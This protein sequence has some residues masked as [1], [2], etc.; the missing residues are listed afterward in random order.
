LLLCRSVEVEDIVV[1]G[2][3]VRKLKALPAGRMGN[4]ANAFVGGFRPGKVEASSRSAQ[5]RKAAGS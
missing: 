5:T 3:N 4:N 2:G 1:G